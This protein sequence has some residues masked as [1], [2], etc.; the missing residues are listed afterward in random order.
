MSCNSYYSRFWE[1][2][3]TIFFENA[4]VKNKLPVKVPGYL[5]LQ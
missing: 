5:F 2:K 4:N 1:G 3:Y